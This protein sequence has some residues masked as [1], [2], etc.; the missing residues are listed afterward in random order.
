MFLVLLN[1]NE[2]KVDH[3]TEV[4]VRVLVLVLVKVKVMIVK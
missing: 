1:G 2:V 4:Q 3:L